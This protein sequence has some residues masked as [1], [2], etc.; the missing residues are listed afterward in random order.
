MLQRGIELST[1]SSSWVSSASFYFIC[2]FGLRSIF[3]LIFG[4][5]PDM[6]EMRMMQQQ[7]GSAGGGAPQDPAKAF[8]GEKEALLITKHKWRLASVEQDYLRSANRFIKGL[9]GRQAASDGA[10]KDK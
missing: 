8:D 9:D 4:A 6:D 2:V 7:M 5:N 10:S 1:L 3:N